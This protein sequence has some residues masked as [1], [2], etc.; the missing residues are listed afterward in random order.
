MLP[1][2]FCDEGEYFLVLPIVFFTDDH[3]ESCFIL[4]LIFISNGVTKPGSPL[5]DRLNRLDRL[6]CEGRLPLEFLGLE[7]SLFVDG[8]LRDRGM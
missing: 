7:P 4:D 8:L 5:L 3:G 6:R 1:I 2:I